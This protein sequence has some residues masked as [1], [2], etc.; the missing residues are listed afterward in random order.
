MA[1][2]VARLFTGNAD[3]R[4]VMLHLSVYAEQLLLPDPE[5][6]IEDHQDNIH[7]DHLP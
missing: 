3:H 2:G 7:L 6:K 5:Q 4:L 1:L